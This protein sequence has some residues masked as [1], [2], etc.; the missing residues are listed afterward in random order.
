MT[1]FFKIYYPLEIEGLTERLS[2]LVEIKQMKNSSLHSIG[3]GAKKIEVLIKEL[4]SF[5]ICYLIDVRSK[6]YSKWHPQFNQKNLKIE[7]EKNNITYVYMGDT[8]GGLPNE[9]SCYNEKGN[10][11]Y[12]ILKE[13]DFFKEG[14]NRLITA[15]EKGV[16]AVI[17]CSES[18]PEACHRSKLIG[19]E[20]LRKGI[21]LN[22][23]LSERNSKSQD[24][25]MNSSENA[26]LFDNQK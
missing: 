5:D 16:K 13:K 15:H 7:L 6:P 18:K 24:E 19:Q 9:K 11:I 3:H 14:L 8:L 25:L 23:I 20:L 4:Q 26:N 22:H 17:M 1:D 10:I 12:E 21:S 2:D